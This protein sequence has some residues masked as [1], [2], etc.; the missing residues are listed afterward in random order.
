MEAHTGSLAGGMKGAKR[1]RR[2]SEALEA[3]LHGRAK[4]LR[5]SWRATSRGPTERRADF[6]RRRPD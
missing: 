2:Q 4:S 1:V 6:R 3:E 5:G